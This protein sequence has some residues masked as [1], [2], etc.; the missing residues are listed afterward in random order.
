MWNTVVLYIV[1]SLLAIAIGQSLWNH[2]R[3]NYTVQKTKHVA[4]F[5][6]AKYK[7]WMDQLQVSAATLLNN[8]LHD[9]ST[10]AH[11]GPPD[12]AVAPFLSAS[13][14]QWLQEQLDSFLLADMEN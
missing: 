11:T 5:Q 10:L 6:A 8:D 13:D 3:D 4:E 12:G 2:F 14:K 1:L 9:A 7:A